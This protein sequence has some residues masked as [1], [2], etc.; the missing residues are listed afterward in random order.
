MPALLHYALYRVLGSGEFRYDR[1]TI[2]VYDMPPPR[3]CQPS[4]Y[5]QLADR[6]PTS[7]LSGTTA[8]QAQTSHKLPNRTFSLAISEPKLRTRRY[9]RVF[10][11]WQGLLR[12]RCKNGRQPSNIGVITRSSNRAIEGHL[13]WPWPF[14]KWQTIRLQVTQVSLLSI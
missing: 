7:K 13:N 5:L 3:Y 6:G 8:S 10:H 2:S 1:S 4:H 11:I 12:L 9:I 14:S